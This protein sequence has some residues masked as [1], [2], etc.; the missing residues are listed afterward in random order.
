MMRDQSRILSQADTDQPVTRDVWT[1]T[2][3][4]ESHSLITRTGGRSTEVWR[5]FVA[6]PR[7]TLLVTTTGVTRDKEA[8][9]K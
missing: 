5:G 6:A 3:G 7:V 8:A 2:I 9:V 4:V 1:M